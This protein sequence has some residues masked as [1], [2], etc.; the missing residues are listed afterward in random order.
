MHEGIRVLVLGTG[1][2]GSGIARLIL[3]KPGL[4]LVGAH[5][6]RRARA[7]IDLGG[8][9][10]LDR[11][12]GIAISAD[13]EST[14]ARTQPHI[15][16][17]ATC[18][19][20]TDALPEITTVVRNRVPVISIAEEM[21]YPAATSP[22]IAA[23][24]DR[25][26]RAHGVAVVGAGINPGFVLD[27]LVITLSGV[28]ADIRS[29]TARRVNDLSPYG[30]SVLTTQGIGLTPEAFR[31]G[32]ED[33][34]VVGHFGFPQ[35]IRMIADTLGWEIE[36][37]EERREPIV[38]AVR[39]TTPFVT[40]EPGTVAGCL[41]TAV[42]FAS[43]EPV[44]SLIHP[45]QIHP[46]LE[47]VETGDSIEIAGTPSV[48]LAGSPEIPGGVGTIALAVNLIPRVL[49]AA[50]GLH[51]MADLPVPAAVL[52]D[53]RRHLRETQREPRHA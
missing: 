18:S 52:G 38:S 14:V 24:L 19:R 5:G 35:S 44:I 7:G 51:S 9:I 32:V 48:R 34:S 20:L 23:E 46:H 16:I 10:G 26:A 30:P 25:L 12:V 39:R 41:H 36:G 45:Q 28:C 2:M 53:V 50:P 11:E 6:R 42:A 17:Q 1:Q 29:I 31:R 3:N 8:A 13:L 33:G 40:V 27:L 15:A 43:G 37:I 47:G 4:A 49:S 22:A 21:A